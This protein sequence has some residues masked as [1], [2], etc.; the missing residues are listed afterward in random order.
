MILNEKFVWSPKWRIL[1]HDKNMNLY[2]TENVDG[3]ILLN[4]GINAMLKLLCGESGINPF[5]NANSYIGVG[6]SAIATSEAQTG[7]QGVNITY[8]QVDDTYPKIDKNKAIV[9]ATF[10]GNTGNHDWKEFTWSNGNSNSSIN[11][12]RKVDDKP[13]TK[14]EGDI[15]VL[16]LNVTIFNG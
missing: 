5:N 6:D 15:W 13:R 4:E 14:V 10:D 12:N 2:E 9:R 16:E 3:N 7:L 8:A 1:K 11:L